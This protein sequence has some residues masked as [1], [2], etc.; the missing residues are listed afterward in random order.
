[1]DEKRRPIIYWLQGKHRWVEDEFTFN[2]T[3]KTIS[4]GFIVRMKEIEEFEPAPTLEEVSEAY[5]LFVSGVR[6]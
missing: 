3:S 5:N 2:T 1:M 4:M 6:I